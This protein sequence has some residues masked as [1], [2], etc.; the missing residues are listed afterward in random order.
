MIYF[1]L[2]FIKKI[3]YLPVVSALQNAD[4]KIIPILCYAFLRVFTKYIERR[5]KNPK[6]LAFGFHNAVTYWDLVSNKKSS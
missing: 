5:L 4:V 2:F 6:V 3:L 1:I